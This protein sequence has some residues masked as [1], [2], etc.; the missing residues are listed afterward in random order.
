LPHR[1]PQAAVTELVYLSVYGQYNN[2]LN[3]K[4]KEAAYHK[5]YMVVWKIKP[6]NTVDRYQ[7]FEGVSYLQL[8]GSKF[9]IKW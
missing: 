9:F 1:I 7:Y 5:Y 3:G 8:Q 6:C 2:I 4:R